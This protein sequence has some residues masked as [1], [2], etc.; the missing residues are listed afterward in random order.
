MTGLAI[1]LPLRVK[2]K[3]SG[4][5]IS[6]HLFELGTNLVVDLVQAEVEML[7]L[8]AAG[9]VPVGSFIAFCISL[10]FTLE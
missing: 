7:E 9:F 4:V 10:Y 1:G 3:S 6:T 5:P 2:P 8:R